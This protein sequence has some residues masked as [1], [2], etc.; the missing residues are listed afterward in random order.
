MPTTPLPT[1]ALRFNLE[2]TDPVADHLDADTGWHGLGGEYI[3][4]LG[5][6]SHAAPGRDPALDTLEASVGAFSRLW[7]GIQPASSLAVS[8]RLSGPERL[9]EQLDTSVRLPKA[10]PGLDF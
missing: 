5:S 10:H 9:L 7:F 6:Q 1:P 8:D 3:V 2:L 4:E